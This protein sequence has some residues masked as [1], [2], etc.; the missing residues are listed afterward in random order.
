[1]IYENTE[2]FPM[3]FEYVIIEMVQLELYHL[4]LKVL[5]TFITL[6]ETLCI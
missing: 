1:M 4:T 3:V 5:H 2:L 6:F